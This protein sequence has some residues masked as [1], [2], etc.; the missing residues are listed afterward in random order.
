M[1]PIK[2]ILISILDQDLYKFAMQQAV[3][4]LFPEANA[5][6]TFINRGPQT[7][8]ENFL[9]QLQY[10]INSFRDLKLS[11][12]DADFLKNKCKYLKLPYLNYLKNYKFDPQEVSAQLVS[13]PLDPQK[14]Q[15]QI[16]I[17]GPWHKTI[18]WEVPLM[19][20]ISEIY[21]QD[22]NKEIDKKTNES[23]IKKTK[24]KSQQLDAA[25]CK[26][27]DFGT[28]RRFGFAAQDEAIKTLAGGKGFMGT[29]NVFFAKKY[30]I[31]PIGTMA[32]EW[33]MGCSALEGLRN[34]NYFALQNW[35]RIY[36][37][38]LGIALTDTYGSD[39]FFKNFNL[40]LSKLYDGLRHDSGDPIEFGYKAIEHYK[41][42]KID[43]TSKTIVFSDG[44]NTDKAVQLQKEFYSKIKLSFG[45][46][47]HFTNDFDNVIPLNMVI[48]LK[49]INDIQVVKISD[50]PA[51][52]T[53]DADALKVAH[54]TFFNTPL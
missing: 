22:T 23:F 38:E 21:F 3:L 35:A 11:S 29:S 45:I 50:T 36:N 18:L 6:Y 49:S 54:W 33:I 40:R 2:P 10:S 9:K 8:S 26:Y 25:N 19:A 4:E 42:F 7:F 47:T 51:K 13:D 1:L 52:A 53:G 24:N 30:N 39:A 16:E 48:K 32:H 12:T 31:K 44:L 27:A 17:N 41:N 43:P 15:L 37:A 14:K 5:K 28:R 46:G 34:A 20:M